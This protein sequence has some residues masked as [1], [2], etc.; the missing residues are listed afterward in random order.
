MA[1]L[2]LLGALWA[3][4]QFTGLRARIN[5]QALRD[6]FAAHSVWGFVAFTALF[7]LG[8]LIQLPGWIFLASAVLALGPAWGAGATFSAALVS[9]AV[10]FVIVRAFGANALRELPGPLARRLFSRLDAHPVRSVA[11]L[12]L[13]FQ[14]V[15]AL[16][17]ALALSGLRFRDYMLG[18]L[19]GLPLPL[20][21]YAAFFDTLAGLMGWQLH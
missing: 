8:N 16:N 14:T 15:P 12:R 9:C 18:T 3:V 2:L 19:I 4:F 17:Y 11:L 6:G 10:T 13:F 20:V 5:P 7:A 1:V 21:V